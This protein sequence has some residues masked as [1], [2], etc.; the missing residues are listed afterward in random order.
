MKYIAQVIMLLII[1]TICV[2]A[3]DEKDFLRKYMPHLE[4]SSISIDDNKVRIASDEDD[5]SVII[6]EYGDLYVNGKHV[7]LDK[8]QQKLV[9]DYREN[10][11]VIIDRAKDIGIEG[12]KL[13]IDGAK[14]GLQAVVGVFKLLDENYDSEDL[15]AELDIASEELEAKAEELELEA[16]ELE[17]LADNLEELHEEL[18]ESI[19]ELEELDSF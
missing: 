5:Y 4:N 6:T 3:A 7:N 2:N 15:E 10:I 19:P 18:K 9:D 1:F 8:N 17:L 11:M 16:E 12:A 13:G 14:I